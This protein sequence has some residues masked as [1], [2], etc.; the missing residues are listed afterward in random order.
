MAGLGAWRAQQAIRTTC[1][2]R[3]GGWAVE[4]GVVRLGF[5]RCIR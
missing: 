4:F 2:Y 3:V 5:P 1:M